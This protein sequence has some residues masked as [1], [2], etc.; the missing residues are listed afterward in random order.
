ML[1]PFLLKQNYLILN[2][3]I[4]KSIFFFLNNILGVGLQNIKV[5]N[6]MCKNI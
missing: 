1:T 2:W 5:G 4:M 3:F 6:T